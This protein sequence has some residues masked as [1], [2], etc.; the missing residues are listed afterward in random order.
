M[1]LPAGIHAVGFESKNEIRNEGKDPWMK[2]K[3]LL[4]IWLLGMMTP[5]AH[6]VVCIPFLA[7]PH[8][9]EYITDNYFGKIPSDRLQVKD[10]VLFFRCDGKRRS[11]L[12]LSPKIAASMAASFDFEKNVLTLI[13]FPVVRNGLYV[14]SKWEMQKDPYSGDV[15]N[16]YND[17]PLADGTQLGP[18]YEIESSSAAMELKPGET[19]G[20]RQITC[21]LQGDYS[22]LRGIAR[23][24]LGVELDEMKKM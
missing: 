20:H 3:G 7:G 1:A 5:T 11:K 21:H 4:S 9:R 8:S 17:G 12:G 23:S 15:V 6:T 14:N 18:F 19:E 10:S 2:E 24:L 16:S 13:F 22:S